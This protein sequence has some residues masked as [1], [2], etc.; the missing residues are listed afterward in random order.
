MGIVVRGEKQYDGC[1]QGVALPLVMWMSR[2]MSWGRY[3]HTYT[4]QFN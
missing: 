3:S 4:K 1:K 2:I